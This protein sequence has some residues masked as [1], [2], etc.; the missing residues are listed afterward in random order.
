MYAETN[1]EMFF[2]SFFVSIVNVF[3]DSGNRR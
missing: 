2:V 1:A 3:Q